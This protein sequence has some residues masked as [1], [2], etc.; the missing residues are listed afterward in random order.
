MDRIIETADGFDC[1]VGGNRFG[2]WRSR[3]EATAGMA[4]EK[5]RLRDKAAL[6]RAIKEVMRRDEQAASQ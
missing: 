3:R 2:T 1:I 4:T 6:L 5:R